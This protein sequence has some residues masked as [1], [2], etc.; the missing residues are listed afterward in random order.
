MEVLERALIER[1]AELIHRQRMFEH[2]CR[3]GVAVSGGADSVCLLEVLRELAPRWRLTL[4][5][6]HLDH[7]LRGE[8]SRADADFVRRMAAD[9]GLAFHFRELDVADLARSTG[10]NLEQAARRARH[11]F[12]LELLRSGALDRVATG[13]TRSDQA[14]TVIFRLLR[15]SGI[16]GLAGIWPATEEGVVRPLLG[17]SRQETREHL[18]RR[19]IPWREDSSNRN[20]ALARNRIRQELLPQLARDWNPA[21]EESLAHLATLAQDEERHAREQI[22]KLTPEHLI[23][24]PDAV[25]IR[26]DALSAMPTALARRLLRRAIEL[27][28]GQL[29]RINFNHLEGM[30]HLALKGEGCGAL[31]LPG[32]A[33]AADGYRVALP[34][35]GSVQVPGSSS[36]ILLELSENEASS[37][38]RGRPAASGYNESGSHLDWERISGPLELRSARPGDQYQPA[39]EAV[40]RKL[41]VLFQ[42]SR[43]PRWDRC[44]WPIIAAGDEIVWARRFG[45]AAGY[46]ASDDTRL[47]LR[48]RESE[49]GT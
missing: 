41:K 49:A 33:S 5:I 3:A 42:R 24:T 37:S 1:V 44:G 31:T 45:A 16:A 22:R 40:R 4:S 15:G 30:L 48:I 9:F 38:T 13:H 27:A 11:E 21:I 43:V 2:G 46:A 6:L 14:E 23:V 10:D 26:T 8:E 47:I 20:L 7:R 25:L 28:R 32:S 18:R 36:T 17:V 34:V 35:P 39:D 29:R 19:G 12:F